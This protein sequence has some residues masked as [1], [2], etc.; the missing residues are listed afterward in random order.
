MIGAQ[1]ETNK[2]RNTQ[3][4]RVTTIPVEKE[5]GRGG[6]GLEKPKKRLRNTNT[7]G[8]VLWFGGGKQKIQVRDRGE[9]KNRRSKKE[10]RKKEK[11]T[12]GNHEE[13][14]DWT[15]GGRKREKRKRG[16]RAGRGDVTWATAGVTAWCWV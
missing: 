12:D 11:L 6:E 9:S 14:Q 3:S 4:K 13:E 16:G 1:N 10:K 15:R 7:P 8:T 2:R 5:G